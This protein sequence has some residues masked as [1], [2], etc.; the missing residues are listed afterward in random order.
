MQT[1]LH[2]THVGHSLPHGAEEVVQAPAK[3]PAGEAAMEAETVGKPK[4]TK[5]GKDPTSEDVNASPIVR[6][7]DG[8]DAAEK[9][10]TAKTGQDTGPS[11]RPARRRSPR[12]ARQ[13]PRRRRTSSQRA[14][15]RAR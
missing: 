10:K 9:P 12:P 11:P 14:T 5:G 4:Q 6:Q 7:N 2:H 8:E 13:R 3:G 1:A 15:R